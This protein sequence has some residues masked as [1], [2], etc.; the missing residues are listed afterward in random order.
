MSTFNDHLKALK[1]ISK[2]L[3]HLKLVDNGEPVQNIQQFELIMKLFGE[4]LEH[5]LDLVPL[6]TNEECLNML[7][8]ALKLKNDE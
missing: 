2:Y 3:Q 7:H 4:Q 5:F 6:F 1:H 8:E